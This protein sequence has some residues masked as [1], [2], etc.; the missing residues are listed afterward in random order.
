M[1]QSFGCTPSV[2]WREL[3]HAPLGPHR[4]RALTR[5][6]SGLAFIDQALADVA[7][8]RDSKDPPPSIDVV[9]AARDIALMYAAD[10]EFPMEDDTG[11]GAE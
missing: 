2:A 7:R 3:G 9:K 4:R 1:C 11:E 10:Q 8:E 6:V 5:A